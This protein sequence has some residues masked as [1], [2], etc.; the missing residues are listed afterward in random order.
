MKMIHPGYLFS[1][2]VTT[3]DNE[4]LYLDCLELEQELLKQIGEPAEAGGYG[5]V[6][7]ANY[8]RYNMF[9]YHYPGLNGMYRALQEKVRPHLPNEQWMVQCWLNVFRKGESIKWHAHWPPECRA[10]HGFYCV[11]VTGSYTHY[12]IN[13]QQ[14]DIEGHNGLLVFGK[15]DNDTHRSGDW[16]REDMCRVTIAFDIIPIEFWKNSSGCYVPL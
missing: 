9:H 6:T 15:S 1:E 12:L 5:N 11:N 16:D 4:H 7:S 10:W 3:I 13:G 2:D 8:R 14:Y